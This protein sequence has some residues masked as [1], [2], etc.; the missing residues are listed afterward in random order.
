[1]ESSLVGLINLVCKW[2]TLVVSRLFINPRALNRAYPSVTLLLCSF[3]WVNLMSQWTY[4][5]E[6]K[7]RAVIS[8]SWRHIRHA[9]AATMLPCCL[10]NLLPLCCFVMTWFCLFDL[11]FVFVFFQVK[12]VWKITRRV[13]ALFCMSAFTETGCFFKP[14]KGTVQIFQHDC[15]RAHH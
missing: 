12:F 8:V 3:L 15:T 13:C 1:M 6:L 2:W 5:H 11:S 7:V 9:Q 14:V 4:Q 10:L